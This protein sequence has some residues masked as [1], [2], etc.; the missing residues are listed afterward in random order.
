MAISGLRKASTICFRG[1]ECPI[2]EVLE[3]T[4]KMFRG[5]TVSCLS[6]YRQSMHIILRF[7]LQDISLEKQA[8][9][10]L[11][12]D[13]FI[14]GRSLIFVHLGVV[15][16]HRI[17]FDEM[18]LPGHCNLGDWVHTQTVLSRE[19]KNC[20]ESVGKVHAFEFTTQARS[21]HQSDT[22]GCD[23]QRPWLFGWN[24]DVDAYR[25]TNANSAVSIEGF[26]YLDVEG[27]EVL[28]NLYCIDIEC[29]YWN[30]ICGLCQESNML[31]FTAMH[32]ISLDKRQLRSIHC[33]LSN[34]LSNFHRRIDRLQ[35][36]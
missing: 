7:T 18:T 15:G 20:R 10:R 29:V 16:E 27:T 9:N 17:L 8:R 33:L 5:G 28:S 30:I 3:V 14:L 21:P 34:L 24:C 36:V 1:Y 12:Y 11:E 25:G 35:R 22:D 31:Q 4:T 19:G 13:G 6:I 32:R 26:A 23:T 2:E